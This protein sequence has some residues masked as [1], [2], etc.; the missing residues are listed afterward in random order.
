MPG[1]L[2]V[3]L[4]RQYRQ[5][6]LNI[7]FLSTFTVDEA[8]LPAQGEAA[9]GFY[10][11]TILGAE[12]GQRAEPRFVRDFEAQFN[13]VP[14]T[15][16]AHAYDS[17]MLLDSAIRRVGGNLADKDALR[18]A[19]RAADFRSVRGLPLR[20]EPLPGA[21]FLAAKVGAPAGRQ[22]PDRDV[23]KVLENAWTPG[24]PNAGCR[25]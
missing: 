19:I 7:P 20:R 21:G 5:A 2:G 17:A 14:A 6:G 22:V 15:Y 16:A 25:R 8:T 9:L 23:R 24:P 3:N 18:T 1:G 10:S 13:Y 12:H 11:G 4:V